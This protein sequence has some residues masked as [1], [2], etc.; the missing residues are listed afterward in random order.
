MECPQTRSSTSQNFQPEKM[1]STAIFG[2]ET[3]VSLVH[4]CIRVS[5]AAVLCVRFIDSLGVYYSEH[6]SWEKQGIAYQDSFSSTTG[7]SWNSL[8]NYTYSEIRDIFRLTPYNDAETVSWTDST[9]VL[10]CLAQIPRFRTTFDG[11]RVSE[12]QQVSPRIQ[13]RHKTPCA[14]PSRGTTIENLKSFKF[15]WKRPIRLSKSEDE[16]PKKQSAI[17]EVPEYRQPKS[18]TTETTNLLA[19]FLRFYLTA[20]DIVGSRS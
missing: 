4:R 7:T 12:I 9:I 1:Y 19:S 13:W 3:S 8:G 5:R 14:N 10:Q 2:Q 6:R 18:R 15:C 11:N 17:T 16:W 20:T